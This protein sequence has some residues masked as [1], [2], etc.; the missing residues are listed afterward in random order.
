MAELKNVPGTVFIVAEYRAEEN[1]APVERG[2]PPLA[3]AH[4]TDERELPAFLFAVHPGNQI[5]IRALKTE[6]FSPRSIS[7]AAAMGPSD[8]T[9]RKRTN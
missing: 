1:A 4:S 3:L 9:P 6:P 8:R 7:G 2:S 5:R